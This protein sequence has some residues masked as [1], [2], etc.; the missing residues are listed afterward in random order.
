MEVN[1]GHV[2]NPKNDVD[3]KMNEKDI[4]VDESEVSSYLI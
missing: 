1:F 4:A 2:R 3:I